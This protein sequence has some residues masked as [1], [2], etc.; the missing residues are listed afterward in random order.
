ML[1]KFN[2]KFWCY[3]SATESYK[4][5]L[6]RDSQKR[7]KQTDNL[8]T[9]EFPK[10]LISTDNHSKNV[11]DLEVLSFQSLSNILKIHHLETNLLLN[12][13]KNWSVSFHYFLTIFVPDRISC[14]GLFQPGHD[15]ADPGVQS[16]VPRVPTTLS[17]AHNANLKIIGLH[18]CGFFLL[19]P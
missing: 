13:G 15:R 4:S 9:F 1:K 19:T 18:F 14:S 3:C 17:Q 10:S 8:S 12:C 6:N 5:E 11:L 16:R 2:L 7:M